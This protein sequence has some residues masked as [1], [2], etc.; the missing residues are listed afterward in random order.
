MMPS[1]TQIAAAGRPTA[2]STIF[3]LLCAG[4]VLNG[5]VICLI[6]PILPVFREKWGLDDNRAGLFSLMQFASSLVGVLI[7]SPLIS[8]KGFKPAITIGLLFLGAGF[9]LLNAPTFGLALAAS[10]IYGLGYGFA[11]PGTN[12]WV[13]ESYGER[14]ASALNLANL[15]WGVGAIASSPLAFFAIRTAHVTLLLYVVGAL[16]AVLGVVLFRMNFGEAPHH[17]EPAGGSSS[18]VSISTAVLLGILFFVY[19]G[20][21]VGTSYWAAMHAQRAAIWGGNGYTLAPM[22]FFAGLLGGRGAA[23]AILLRVPESTVASGG[24]LLAGAGE[25]LFVSS[26]SATPLFAGAFFAGLGLSSLYPIYV[27]WLTKWFGARARKVGG[28]M[29]A[30]AALGSATMPWLVGV[31]SRA[32]SSLRSGL[33]VPLVGCLVMLAAVTILRPNRRA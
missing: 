30:M 20:T 25:L 31:I 19:V 18:A 5:I 16:C 9:A 2:Q 10:A 6:G 15:A 14:R 21:E 8:A 32:S 33:S 23:A 11:T 13:G 12:L 22:F 28:V 1:K 7:S 3:Y 17:D 29:F 27:S 26:H 24:L 4:F